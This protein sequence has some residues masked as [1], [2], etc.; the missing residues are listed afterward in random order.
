MIRLLVTP[1]DN[2]YFL[3]DNGYFLMDNGYFLMD[4][5]CPFV[6]KLDKN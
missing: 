3:M 1:L 2:G 4:N 5:G 6:K